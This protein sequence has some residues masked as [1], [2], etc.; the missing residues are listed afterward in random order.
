MSVREVPARRVATESRPRLAARL[1]WVGPFAREFGVVTGIVFAYFLLRGL[2]PDRPDFAIEVAKQVI[3]I[4]QAL[5]LYHEA[6]IQ[7]ASIH[8]GWMRETANFIYAYAHFPALIVV[9]VWLWFTRR[10]S[11]RE[12]RNT[13]FVSMVAGLV[14]Y[15]V[16]PTAPPRLLEFHGVE[17]SFVDTIFGGGTRV[18][19]AQPGII[20]NE[21]AAI[22]SFHFGWMIVASAAL[23][24]GSRHPALRM[25]ALVLSVLMSWA[26]VAT[27]NHFFADM[28][29]GGVVVVASWLLA[30]RWAGHRLL[31]W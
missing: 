3:A 28:I 31:R 16:L 30:R 10:G 9:A 17:S 15:Y 4:E 23:W 7:E 13:L 2:A 14:F 5:G 21:Y 8:W 18:E 1:A 11:Y 29:L 27:G 26:I 12:L 24:T 20:L 25:A 6:A 19:Y 22:P